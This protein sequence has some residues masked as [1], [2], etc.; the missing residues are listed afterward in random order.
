MLNFIR[1]I[2]LLIM[3]RSIYRVFNMLNEI[4]NDIRVTSPFMALA[5]NAGRILI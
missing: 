1:F 5:K 3:G 2:L 4:Y